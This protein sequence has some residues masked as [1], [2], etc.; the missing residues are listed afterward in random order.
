[1]KKCTEEHVSRSVIENKLLVSLG[2]K[3]KV[4]LL[5]DKNDLDLII[6]ALLLSES[7]RMAMPTQY[8]EMRKGLE[9]LRAA[10]FKKE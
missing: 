4:A 2:D 9:Q 7:N 1:M 5:L 6:G 8:K 3:S 10:A